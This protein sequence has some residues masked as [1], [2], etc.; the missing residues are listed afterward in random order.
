[1]HA[2]AHRSGFILLAFCVPILSHNRRSKAVRKAAPACLL[3]QPDCHM[4][5]SSATGTSAVA[6][7]CGL[8]NIFKHTLPP[9]TLS[10]TCLISPVCLCRS[11]VPIQLVIQMSPLLG[12]FHNMFTHIQEVLRTGNTIITPR[13]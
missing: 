7:K 1:M 3:Q 11:G 9:H 4:M 12:K 2:Q 8:R 5:A 6:D 10:L 13:T